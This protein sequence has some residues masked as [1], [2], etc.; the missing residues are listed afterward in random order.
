MR[1]VDAPSVLALAA[2]ATV[3]C[4]ASSAPPSTSLGF[5]PSSP[6][7][8]NFRFG[9]AASGRSLGRRGM[10]TGLSSPDDNSQDIPSALNAQNPQQAPPATVPAAATS[11]PPRLAPLPPVSP[12]FIESVGE[13]LASIPESSD[14]MSGA[15]R[16]A[17]AAISVVTIRSL[18]ISGKEAREM[19]QAREGKEEQEGQEEQEEV[20]IEEFIQSLKEEISVADRSGNKKLGHHLDEVKYELEELRLMEERRELLSI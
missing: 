18:L 16:A 5:V 2:L 20:P 4:L 8:L 13:K 11:P 19:A 1:I 3:L 9:L 15:G 12:D 6:R 7:R 14:N 17:L 10:S